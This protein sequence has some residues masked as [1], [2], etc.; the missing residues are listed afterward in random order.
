MTDKVLHLTRARAA[1]DEALLRMVTDGVM[2]ADAAHAM[3]GAGF[4]S[5]TRIL[6][7]L[8][9][10]GIGADCITAAFEAELDRART[11]GDQRLINSTEFTLAV[12][13]G[14]QEDFAAWLESN[15]GVQR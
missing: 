6:S 13:H 2:T 7:E 9:V 4:Y 11:D 1:A 5:A 3:A 14:M 15:E 10:S 12:W 8:R